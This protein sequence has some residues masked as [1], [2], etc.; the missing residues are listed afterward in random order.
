MYERLYRYLLPRSS[1][2]KHNINTPEIYIQNY[3]TFL[4]LFRMHRASFWQVVEMLAGVNGKDY[5][6][7]SKTGRP[8]RPIY[9]QI[10]VALY[11]LGGGGS[12]GE[13]TRLALNLGQRLYNNQPTS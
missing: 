11:I 2:E 5:W 8:S 6:V 13:R 9:Q 12:T 4:N 3:P 10:A 7:Q 1:A